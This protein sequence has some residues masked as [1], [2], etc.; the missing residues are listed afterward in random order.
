MYWEG[1]LYHGFQQPDWLLRHF[2]SPNLNF[3]HTP[4]HTHV[5]VFIFKKFHWAKLN[6]NIFSENRHEAFFTSKN[7]RRNTQGWALQSF[8]FRTFLLSRSF[9]ERSVLSRSFFE[10]LATHET[11]KNGTFFP[12]LLKRTGKNV[13]NVPF[14]CK[15]HERTQRLSCSFIK[16]GKER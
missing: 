5:K 11:Q 16:N 3:R 13:K 8:P 2:R 7:K 12:I 9:K 10:F 1:K 14:F 4:L 15:E 6:L